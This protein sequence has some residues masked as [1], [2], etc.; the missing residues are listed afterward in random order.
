M[1]NLL[2]LLYACIYAYLI[3]YAYRL[4]PVKDLHY[5]FF[6]AVLFALFY[7]CLICAIGF[8][9]GEGRLLEALNFLRFAMHVFITPTLCYIAF[10]LA[11]KMQ[12]PV[13]QS[14]AAEI[15][16]WFLIAIFIVW[17]FLHDIAPM[18]LKPVVFFG[19]LAYS[20]ATPSVPIPVILINVFVIIVSVC[21][22]KKTGWPVLFFTSVAMMCIAAIQIKEL[23]QLPGNAGEILFMYGFLLAQ[24]KVLNAKLERA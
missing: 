16:V 22:W 21:I 3:I 17:G 15:V 12:V 24:R 5:K 7:D 2:F 4:T 14:K 1:G 13:A 6:L 8:L 9:V 19:V 11:Q 10:K 20:H 18:D 23:G